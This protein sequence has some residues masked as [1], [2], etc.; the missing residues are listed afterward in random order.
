[1]WCLFLF[2]NE[3]LRYHKNEDI[4]IKRQF[5]VSNEIEQGV[6]KIIS[7]TSIQIY[8]HRR[9]DETF[10]YFIAI[11]RLIYLLRTISSIYFE[12]RFY[13]H[14]QQKWEEEKIVWK[15]F[16]Q[17]QLQSISKS[18]QR[19]LTRNSSKFFFYLSILVH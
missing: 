1:M 15:C 10:V 7:R 3:M 5:K 14:Q 8:N 2:Y 18:A 13:S 12:F 16:L 4:F 19:I 11:L 17:L 9:L 6:S